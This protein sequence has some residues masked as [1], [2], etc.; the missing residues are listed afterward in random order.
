[1]VRIEDGAGAALFVSVLQIL[2]EFLG[3]IFVGVSRVGP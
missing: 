1:M 3:Q 2:V